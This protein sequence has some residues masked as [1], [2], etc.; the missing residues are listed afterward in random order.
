MSIMKNINYIKKLNVIGCTTPDIFVIVETG[1]QSAGPALLNLFTPGCSE[2]VKMKLGL[3]PWHLRKVNTFIKGAAAPFA[4]EANKF[5]YKIG[6]FTAERGLYHLMVA[7][8]AVEFFTT[9]QSLAFAAEQ[10]PL[11]SA[12]TAYGYIATFIYEPGQDTLLGYYPLHNVTGMAIGLNQ[13]TIFP[14]FQGTVAFSAVFDSWP[15]RGQGVSVTTWITEDDNPAP[16]S[17]FKTNDPP[18]QPKN[19]TVGHLSFD[20]LRNLVRK[21]YYLHIQNTGDNYAQAVGGSYTIAMSG[22]PTGVLPWGCKLK[23]TSVP[24]T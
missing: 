12:G 22:H 11:P 24:F 7:D 2:I 18:S 5:L 17:T 6:Y 8:I 14:G 13:I 4:L 1:L 10:C 15:T 19:E 21:D 23:K 16:I 9:W 20:T 3:S